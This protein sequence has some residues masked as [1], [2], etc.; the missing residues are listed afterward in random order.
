MAL[1]I[2]ALSATLAA[3]GY[4]IMLGTLSSTYEQASMFGP[5]SI[6]IAAAIGGVM[7]PV[8]AMPKLMQNLSAFSPLEWG[9]GAFLDILV[10]GGDLKTVLPD[11]ISMLLLFAVMM[12]VSWIFF[13]ARKRNGM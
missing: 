5:I 8:Y 2:I 12:S 3:T 10:R 7:V 11:V 13:F 9:L 4:G 1:L 6:V